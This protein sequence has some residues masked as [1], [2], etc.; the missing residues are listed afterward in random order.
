MPPNMSSLSLDFQIIDYRPDHK[1][2]WKEI[3]ESWILDAYVMEEID[4]LHCSHPETSILQGGG[5][6]LLAVTA[7]GQVIGTAG[8][9]KDDPFT[10][11]LIKM[12]VD[13]KYRGHGIGK[14]LCRAS[15]ERARS[16]GAKTFYLFSNRAGSAKAIELY[17]SLG[18]MEVPLDRNDFDRADIRME[19][20]F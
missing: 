14:A 11:E 2:R 18:F 10:Y 8:L 9:L 15:I 6:I 3:N 1:Q 7:D 20:H 12:A 13:K 16:L 17:R 19:M 4:H 5:Q